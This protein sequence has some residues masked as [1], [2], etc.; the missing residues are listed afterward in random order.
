LEQGRDIQVSGEVLENLVGVLQLSNDERLRLFQLARRP[1]PPAPVHDPVTVRPI[2]HVMP[3]A[4]EPSPAHI[5]D[6]R[7]NVLAWNRA[8]SFLDDWPAYPLVERNV[9][10]HHFAHPRLRRLMVNWEEEARTLLALFRMESGHYLCD[11]WFASMV[12]Q[13]QQVSPEFR[14]WWSLHEVQ[15]KRERPIAFAH[16]EV[17]RL[18]LQP[19]TMLFAYDRQLSVRVLLPSPETDTAAKLLQLMK[20]RGE[21]E[22]HGEEQRHPNCPGLTRAP[23]SPS[24]NYRTNLPIKLRTRA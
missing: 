23:I 21:Q 10:W 22:G 14:Q 7:W 17:G 13:L 20:A 18:L 24:S 2:F 16:P 9:V 6:S 5:R 4:L 19:F 3:S 15:Q 11:P 1:L 12:E 8:E